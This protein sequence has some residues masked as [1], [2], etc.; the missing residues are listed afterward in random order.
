LK[1]NSQGFRGADFSKS[2]PENTTRI[3]MIGDSYTAGLDYPDNVIFSDQWAQKLNATGSNKFEVLNASCPAWGTDQEYLFWKKEGIDL[4]PDHVVIM[5]SPNDVR[6]TWNH[7][8]VRYNGAKKTLEVTE[9]NLPFKEKIGW[10]LASKSSFYQFLQKK[11]FNTDHGNFLRV[12]WSFPV[13]YGIQ[14]ST[15]WNMPLF[16]KEP[17]PALE[18]SYELLEEIYVD[19][20]EDC[21]EMGAELHIV[22]IPIRLEIDD[23]YQDSTRFNRRII[24]QRIE[25]IAIRNGIHFHNL[26]KELR[27]HPSPND[28]YMDWESHYDEGGHN[29]IAEMLYKHVKL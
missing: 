29:W 3:L 24:E 2:V 11:V 21:E 20:K 19:I 10:K 4:Y 16:L 17:F 18:D 9:P 27:A 13:N 15:D 1:F 8:V 23:T 6:E 26:N 12:F 5:M 14:D 28:I 25:N 7:N 22:K